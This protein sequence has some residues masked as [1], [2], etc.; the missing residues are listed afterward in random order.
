MRILFLEVFVNLG[1]VADHLGVCFDSGELNRGGSQSH[2]LEE[3]SRGI[4]TIG[5]YANT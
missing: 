4:R 2:L 5:R 1:I 3:R